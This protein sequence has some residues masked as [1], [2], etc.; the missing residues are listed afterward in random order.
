MKNRFVPL[1]AAA[2]FIAG[3]TG[4]ASAATTTFV[5]PTGATTGGG[6]VSASATF[7]TSAGQIVLTLTNNTVNPT[8]VA[9][10]L[11]AITF[12]TNP[13]TAAAGATLISGIGNQRFVS[14]NGTWTSGLT[15]VPAGWAFSN[16][17]APNFNLA[18]NVLGSGGAGPAHTLIG[19]PAASNIYSAANGSIAGNGPH[20]PFLYKTIVFTFNAPSVT[21]DTTISSATFQFG[22]TPGS[23]T[24]V[25]VPSTVPVPVPAA[26]WTGL[27]AL[28]SLG[29]FGKL[30]KKLCRD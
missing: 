11:S 28:A 7:V 22:T 25:G 29:L 20:N 17:N 30:R 10:N 12:N 5:T 4:A 1:M 27:S 26:A 21:A 3:A 9:Q 14:A 23:N 15:N 2:I 19:D 24:V 18:V 6:P 8:D 13:N 16:S